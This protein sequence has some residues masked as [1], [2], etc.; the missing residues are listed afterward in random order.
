MKEAF[1]D[2]VLPGFDHVGVDTAAGR[3]WFA[4]TVAEQT[5]S[6]ARLRSDR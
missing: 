3:A 1:A 6:A 4:H 5:P 2:L